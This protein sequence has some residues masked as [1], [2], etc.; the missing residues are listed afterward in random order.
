M[1]EIIQLPTDPLF[2]KCE[3]GCMYFLYRLDGVAVCA[4]CDLEYEAALEINFEFEDL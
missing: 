3:C 2:L 4:E 1:G